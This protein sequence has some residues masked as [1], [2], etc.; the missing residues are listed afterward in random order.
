MQMQGYTP[1]PPRRNMALL[2]LVK[3][4]LTTLSRLLKK[5]GGPALGGLK[6]QHSKRSGVEATQLH[7]EAVEVPNTSFGWEF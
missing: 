6:I 2:N 7:G 3:G 4:L 1:T 5:R